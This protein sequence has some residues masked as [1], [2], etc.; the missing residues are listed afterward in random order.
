[1]CPAMECRVRRC[2]H[3][4]ALAL[5]L[6]PALVAASADALQPRVRKLADSGAED[7][8]AGHAL[9]STGSRWPT[10]YYSAGVSAPAGDVDGDGVPDVVLGGHGAVHVL[11][12]PL[13]PQPSLRRSLRDGSA[14]RL[15][16]PACTPAG[17]RVAVA[18]A[19]DVNCDGLADVVVTCGGRSFVLLGRRRGSPWPASVDAAPAAPGA[20]SLAAAGVGDVNG[21]GCDDLAV[22]R[23]DRSVVVVYGRG[24]SLWEGA[25]GIAAP[26]AA[27]GFVVPNA[28]AFSGA[29]DVDG[30]GIGD[31]L[32]GDAGASTSGAPGAGAAF[33]VFG[34][35]DF[36]GHFSPQRECGVVAFEGAREA[37]AIGLSV[38][39]AGDV[40][41]DG[42]ADFVVGLSGGADLFTTRYLVVFGDRAAKAT[43]PREVVVDGTQLRLREGLAGGALRASVVVANDD[44]SAGAAVLSSAA[45]DLNGDGVSDV[46]LC[47][48]V[49]TVLMGSP[50]R[51][52]ALVRAPS[53]AAPRGALVVRSGHW[54][55]SGVGPLGDIDGDG[56]D[57]LLLSAAG[58]DYIDPSGDRE[59]EALGS[60]FVL[61]GQRTGVAPAGRQLVLDEVGHEGL[62][63][64]IRSESDAPLLGKAVRG[65]GDLNN[66][67]FDDFAV[68]APGVGRVYLRFG[69]G[70]ALPE[71][72][73]GVSTDAV[74]A[75]S[76]PLDE[77]GWS[78]SPAG[79]LNGDAVADVVISVVCDTVWMEANRLGTE[80]IRSA[81]TAASKLIVIEGLAPV[82]PR[83]MGD[84]RERVF[85]FNRC[86]S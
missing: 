63:Y 43:W 28:S 35:R 68:G 76:E 74:L 29:G 4:L 44:V 81:C 65:L 3:R 72:P 69:H 56:R 46:V 25:V 21:D 49:C 70:G 26:A 86:K 73:A 66:D 45:G 2:R 31:V 55:C 40:N 38:S 23:E 13:A 79:D 78:V 27:E 59:V 64:A 18:P 6:L 80:A 60:S 62:G 77:F 30:D 50:G 19:G 39:G 84:S 22:S 14:V 12:G 24:Q 85:A 83:Q 82:E 17:G 36:A 67:S 42:V 47:H 75:S 71:E 10:A 61:K 41:A 32:F 48:R 37:D 16:A 53:S 1:M 51:W 15:E 11:L 54:N 33:L 20:G 34:R 52:P 5:L 8:V 9:R 58:E 57:D 7:V